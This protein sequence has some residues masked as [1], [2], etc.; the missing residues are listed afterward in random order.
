MEYEGEQQLLC[1]GGAFGALRIERELGSGAF[2][3]VWL[4]R[5]TRLAR[6]VAL[7][8]LHVE[9]VGPSS[10]TDRQRFLM[11]AKVI[12]GFNHPNVVVLYHLHEMRGGAFAL[13][14]EYLDGGTLEDRLAGGEPVP[15]EKAVSIA[16]DICSALAAAHAEGVVH[17]DVKP[18]NVLIGRDGRV[19]LADFGL[20]RLLGVHDL[21]GSQRGLAGTPRYLAPEVIAG[22]AYRSQSE[23][24]SAG[25][26]LYRL[27]AG[28]LPFP[29]ST[30]YALFL[31]IQNDPP[32]PL[33]VEIPPDLARIL[34]RALQK[35]PEDRFADGRELLGALERILRAPAPEASRAAM[36][37]RRAVLSRVVGR[38]CEAAVL[39]AGLDRLA[40]GAGHAFVVTGPAGIGK[41]TLV[42]SAIEEAKQRGWSTI[43]A[44]V[45]PVAG[46]LRRLIDAAGG[47]VGDPTPRGQAAAE[48]TFAALEAALTDRHCP[49]TVVAV[50]DL[51][52]ATP[53]EAQSLARTILRLSAEPILWLVS[54]RTSDLGLSGSEHLRADPLLDIATCE[55]LHVGPLPREAISA[56]VEAQAD[57]ARV[58][59][60]VM[61]RLVHRSEGNPLFAAQIFR[62]MRETAVVVRQWDEWLPD[63][64]IAHSGAPPALREIVRR[65]LARLPESARA[66]FDV[67]AVD[68]LE[69]DGEA[70]AAVLRRPL[71]SVLRQLQGLHRSHGL[72]TSRSRGYRFAHPLLQEVIYA[73]V[74]ADLRR[75]VHRALAEHLEGRG[76]EV[77]PERLGVHWER[78]DLPSRACRYLLRAAAA[79]A[80]RL[81]N[82]R[83]A[84]LAG[85]AGV[86]GGRLEVALAREHAEALFQVAGGLGE[87]GR[88][89]ERDQLY[90]GLL[91]IANTTGDTRLRDRV[92][93]R[94]GAT[95]LVG[96]GLQP[97]DEADIRIAAERLPGSVDK[98]I[99][100]FALGLFERIQGRFERADAEFRAADEQFVQ[101]GAMGRHGTV[102]DQL[103]TIAERTGRLRRAAELFSEAAR[104][105]RRAGRAA[106][107]AI[108]E[109]N[110][111]TV[112]MS[113]GTIEGLAGRLEQAARL[114]DIDG[115]PGS[116]ARVR[117]CEADVLFA[118]GE[119]A[120]ARRIAE[121]ALGVVR[122]VN[123]L[124]GLV[125]AHTAVAYY[126]GVAGETERAL[127]EHALAVEAATRQ[128][129]KRAT[130]KLVAL[131]SLLLARA[132][133]WTEAGAAA[134]RAITAARADPDTAGR[135]EAAG[136]LAEAAL[137]GLDAALLRDVRGLLPGAA[138][139]GDEDAVTRSTRALV[140]GL[141]ARTD[142]SVAPDTVRRCAQVLLRADAGP[143]RA[144]LRMAGHA[145]KA[146]AHDRAGERADA[147]RARDQ[148]AREAAGVGYRGA[149]FPVL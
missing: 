10:Q 56:I 53:E 7:K 138:D 58:S 114:L 43:V 50:E 128:G 101:H 111:I 109:V 120:D 20:A 34:E 61:D 143:R 62:H 112:E 55:R 106:N 42:L 52:L 54:E 86:L 48:P 81:E 46:L 117:L 39:A 94:R 78:S 132:Q 113:L 67:A 70:I 90:E 84:D 141:L 1:V 146:E 82:Y 41:S 91:H 104:V 108:S 11:E 99:A 15:P 75:A 59:G 79:A 73:D 122:K 93:A 23:V 29:Q 51:H 87:L 118:L 83:C 66:L 80:N 5:D 147:A 130:T 28:R 8:V 137:A 68:G 57:G 126:A 26:L 24:W 74:A 40:G 38:D 76:S 96:A 148:A 35:R 100:H 9:G 18:A 149:A 77:D 17:G 4:A 92:H 139:D 72:V 95:R 102:L 60:A 142:A 22:E 44:S 131:E 14:M 69:F 47:S 63:P 3:K 32:P 134:S 6:S 33:G 45:T 30:L 88:H 124:P 98:G 121:A 140:D 36:P 19:K 145:L 12:A 85:R 123:V 37:T 110:A 21:T 16:R 97:G 107:A 135:I 129:N 31:A 105:C 25:V 127:S 119:L 65:R 115:L 13:E 64:S 136:L 89:S 27:L 125:E 116:A 144:L 2:G 133:R 49:A 103:G 71:L